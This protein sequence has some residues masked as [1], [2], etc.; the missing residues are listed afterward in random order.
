MGG[1]INLQVARV[2][3]I[4]SLPDPVNGIIYGDITFQAGKG[5]VTWRATRGNSKF[6]GAGEN[7]T[8]GP[9]KKNTLDFVFPKDQ[10]G[11]RRMLQLAEDD[12]FIVLYIDANGKQKIFGTRDLPAYF[13]FSQDTGDS[14]SARNAFSCRFYSEGPDNSYF[15]NGEISV[16]PGGS[17]PALVKVGSTVLAQLY[18]GDV[19]TITSGFTFGFRLD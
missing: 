5:W 7:T 17:A 9:S 14:T 3:D 8:E 18:P 1:I 2:A 10:S 12:Q 16:A 15:Y 6:T 11:L 13:S 4:V 19:F